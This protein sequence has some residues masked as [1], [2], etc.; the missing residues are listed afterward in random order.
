[1]AEPAPLEKRPFPSKA[2]RTKARDRVVELLRVRAGD[3][4]ANPGNWR[5]HPARQRAA[6]RGL[7]SE[8]ARGAGLPVLPARVDPEEVPAAPA[9]PK[10]RRG[11]LWAVGGHRLL[12]GD[13]TS[14]A[15]VA[16]LMR[17]ERADLLWTDPPYG[18]AYTG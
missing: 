17:G 9:A 2:R 16:R 7:L 14:A 6:L 13:A 12:C 8:L 15:D 10:S 18:V 1:M 11:D 4:V 5:R 3:L